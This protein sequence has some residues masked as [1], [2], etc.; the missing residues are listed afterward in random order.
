MAEAAGIAE[1][2][3]FR[4]FPDKASL[5]H[6]AA[7]ISIDP[8]PIERALA[9]ID[10][11]ASLESQL[12]E[13][14]R[15]LLERFQVVITLMSV[16]RTMPHAAA[17]MHASGPPPYVAL[18]NQ[19]INESVARIFERHRASLRLDPARAAA[20]FRGLILASAHPMVSPT[21]RPT[22]DE[23][24]S[25]LMSGVVEPAMEVVS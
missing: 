25:V 5:I 8:E 21:D 1:G 4:V 20:A 12:T 22:I 24:V 9:R 19:A 10:P 18:A 17:H 7:R 11:E 14:A 13:A 16:L 2:T 15:V 6:E 3:I 23:V